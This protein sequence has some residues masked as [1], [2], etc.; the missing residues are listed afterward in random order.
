TRADQKVQSLLKSLGAYVDAVDSAQLKVTAN[1]DQQTVRSVEERAGVV[2]APADPMKLMEVYRF[3][4]TE[5]EELRKART[6]IDG[7]RDLTRQMAAAHA[8]LAQ[9]AK[10]ESADD[11]KK[12]LGTITDLASSLRQLISAL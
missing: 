6:A 11:T 5:D 9:A 4:R 8:A 1:A 7:Y 3:A 12:A 10:T 2:G